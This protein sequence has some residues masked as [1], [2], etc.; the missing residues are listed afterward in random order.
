MESIL[1]VNPSLAGI[2]STSFYVMPPGLLCLAAY[3]RERGYDVDILDINVEKAVT[4][5]I[6]QI[7]R[8][9]YS[10][11]GVSI[12]VAGQ[13][14]Q[15]RQIL[16]LAKGYSIPTVVGGA[17]ASQFPKELLRNCTEID[18]VVIGEGEEQLLGIA[19]SGKG[20]PGTAYRRYG[21]IVIQSKL[22]YIAD[23]D[24]LPMPAYNLVK[25][26]DYVMDTTTWHNPYNIDFGVRVP[27]ITSRGCPNLCN[28]CSVSKCM[29]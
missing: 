16:R 3:M 20:V 18:F 5:V 9:N 11:V 13:L 19:E 21:S 2:S 10:L 4:S 25:F 22:N 23:M 28:F 7:W 29:G 24:S 1:L 27:L 15:A 14:T 12:M 6:A 17:H 26:S 8:K